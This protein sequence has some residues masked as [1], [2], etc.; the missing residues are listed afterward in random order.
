MLRT[1][2][3]MPPLHLATA[4][5]WRARASTC[6]LGL[7]LAGWL[8][9]GCNLDHLVNQATLPPGVTSPEITQSRAGAVSAYNA[10]LQMFASAYAGSVGGL[11]TFVPM[12][13]L[14]TDELQAS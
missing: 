6:R 10:A 4:R 11:G 9:T 2:L 12:V 1:T 14:L 7:V 3:V 5:G 13:G 8:L